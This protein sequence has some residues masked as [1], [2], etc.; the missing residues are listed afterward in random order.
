LTALP[1]S[2]VTRRERTLFHLVNRSR[3]KHGQARLRL[4][5]SVSRLA[6]RHSVRMAR[7]GTLF[8]QC[9]SCVLNH[10]RWRRIGENIGYAGS[11]RVMNRW[12]M[13][14]PPHR[15]N[16]LCGCFTRVGIGIVRWGGKLWVTEDFYRP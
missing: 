6:R 13:H 14:S 2:A 10:H 12:F 4:S 11:A 16:M 1:A 3:V 5:A 15:E 8:H 9:M 7:L